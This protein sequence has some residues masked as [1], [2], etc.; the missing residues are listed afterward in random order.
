MIMYPKFNKQLW[1]L[2]EVVEANLRRKTTAGLQRPGL[3]CWP[4][5]KKVNEHRADM[6]EWAAYHA[7]STVEGESVLGS[8]VTL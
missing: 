3:R 1:G 5:A 8:A 2:E 4:S 7:P 6:E